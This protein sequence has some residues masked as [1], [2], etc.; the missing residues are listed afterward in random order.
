[1]EREKKKETILFAFLFSLYA[2]I[3][4]LSEIKIEEKKRKSWVMRGQKQ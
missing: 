1:M 3:D 2:R 4:L